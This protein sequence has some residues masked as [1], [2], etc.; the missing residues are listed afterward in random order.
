MNILLDMFCGYYWYIC[1]V[2]II[3][4]IILFFL[5]NWIGA[6]SISVGYMQMNITIRDDSAPAF[7]FLFKVVSPIVFM[8]LC[9]IV[10]EAMGFD[11]FNRNIYFIVIFYW[12]I[13]LL[14]IL[15]ASRSL[16]TNW[17]EQCLY[18]SISIGLS[19]FVYRLLDSVDKILPSPRALLDQLWILIIVFIYSTL[20]RV[21]IARSQT[22]KRK[23]NYIS[24]KYVEFRNKYGDVVKECV[25]NDFYEALTYSIMI[26]EDFNR[27]KLVR[28]IEYIHFWLKRKPHTLG[29]MQVMTKEYI[30][31]NTSIRIAVDK[32]INDGKLAIK[33]YSESSYFDSSCVASNIAHRYNSGDANYA[34][35]VIDVYNYISS[36]FYKQIPN[37]HNEFVTFI[38]NDRVEN[39]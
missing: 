23:N 15:C 37:S 32:I 20:N 14:W 11:L 28:Y 39:I 24:S 6:K 31:D 10:F 36:K 26:Y 9:A 16:L 21:N 2:H 25:P 33:E 5:V 35:E 34:D 29:I 8:V 13:R 17:L 1:V 4:A 12:L 30:D 38:S 7:N 22:I 18:W 27:P 3:L 19:V